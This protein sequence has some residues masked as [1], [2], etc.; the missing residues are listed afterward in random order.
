MAATELMVLLVAT[1][2]D[3]ALTLKHQ[4]YQ[5]DANFTVPNQGVIGL[6]GPSGSGKTSLL[7]VIAGLDQPHSGTIRNGEETWIS[8]EGHNLSAGQRRVGY[9]FQDMRLFP[10]LTVQENLAL[11]AKWGRAPALSEQLVEALELGTLLARKPGRL[12]GGEKRR[13][14]LARA[15]A[16][17]PQLLLLDEPLNGLDP[18]QR[19]RVLKYLSQA[20]EFAKIPAIFV[21]HN[22]DDVGHLCREFIEVARV[23][24]GPSDALRRYT[25]LAPKQAGP[26]IPAI[27]LG[28]RDALGF[29]QFG[30]HEVSLPNTMTSNEIESGAHVYLQSAHG[31]SFLANGYVVPPPNFVRLPVNVG[32]DDRLMVGEWPLDIP[33]LPTHAA[34][35]PQKDRLNL[36]VRVIALVPRR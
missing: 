2:I 20:I 17:A 28:T 3:I 32:P 30:A 24:K 23:L 19:L 36:Y 11:A 14:A 12:S 13:V 35:L 7:R 34:E 8:P 31:Q 33:N 22:P 6:V 25:T 18:D 27:W 16:Q 26:Q 29:V 5:L 21:S 4:N 15:L 10:H 1:M 9:V